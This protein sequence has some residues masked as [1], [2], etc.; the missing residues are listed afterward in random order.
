ML[1][2][3]RPIQRDFQFASD[4]NGECHALRI[5]GISRSGDIDDPENSAVGWMADRDSRAGPTLDSGA[6]M[7]TTM[8]L[9]DPLFDE[10]RA[11]GVGSDLIL[12]PFASKLEMIF[13]AG[14]DNPSIAFCGYD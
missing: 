4:G 3:K 2:S 6:K 9:H 5:E 11:D 10:R 13:P 14:V 7:L 1:Y 12:S 8:N